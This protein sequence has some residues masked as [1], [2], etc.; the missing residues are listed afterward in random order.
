MGLLFGPLIAG[1]AIDLSSSYLKGTDGYQVLWPICA[2]PVLLAIPI[3]ANLI[4]VEPSGR[5]SDQ[6]AELELG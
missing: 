5:A 6:E 2:L 1:V 3:V 4:R